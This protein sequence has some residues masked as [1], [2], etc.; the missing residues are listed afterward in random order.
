MVKKYGINFEE[1][2]HIETWKEFDDKFTLR[3]HP[4]FK[5]VAEYYYASSCLNKVKDIKVPTMVIH[6]KDDPII[7]I[8]CLPIDECIANDK[9]IVGIVRKGGHVCYF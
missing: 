6:S 1:I 9:I 8:D 7:P 2:K 5:T 4:N 3:V